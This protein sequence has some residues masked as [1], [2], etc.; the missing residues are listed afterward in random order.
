[1]G[2]ALAGL[3]E[4]GPVLVGGQDGTRGHGVGAA[5]ADR[6]QGN[7]GRRRRPERRVRKRRRPTRRVA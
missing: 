5:A 3:Q 1:M 6:P 2:V 7:V 4:L